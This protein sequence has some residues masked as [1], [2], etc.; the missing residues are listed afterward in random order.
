MIFLF[1]YF[2]YYTECT[3]KKVY[4]WKNVPKIFNTQD[5]GKYL[6][7]IG[8]FTSCGLS[9]FKIITNYFTLSIFATLVTSYCLLKKLKNKRT[10]C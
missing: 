7:E 1:H 6:A 8:S 4:S 3:R 2:T 5:L 9:E 10:T